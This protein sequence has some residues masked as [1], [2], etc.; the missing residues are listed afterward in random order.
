[1]SPLDYVVIAVYVTGVTL[2]GLAASRRKQSTVSEYFLGNRRVPWLAAS[3]SMI[4]TGISAKSLIGLPGLSYTKDLTYLQ[5]Y[6]VLP[7][8]ALIAATLFLPFYSRIKI[9]SAYEYL[10][11]RFGRGVQSYAS[12]I[13]QIETALILGDGHRRAEAW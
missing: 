5:M 2:V 11:R 10:G 12:L 13:F 7:L 3:A 9:T 4:A 1:M 8:A 6:L